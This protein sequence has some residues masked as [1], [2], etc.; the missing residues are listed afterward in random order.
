MWHRGHEAKARD[1][2]DLCLVIQRSPDALRSASERLLRHRDAFIER[3]HARREILEAQFADIQA[4]G[5]HPSFDECV[6]TA[7]AYLRD[8]TIPDRPSNS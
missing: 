5:Y 2:F 7:T 6:E 8:L 3:A 1:L 4:I